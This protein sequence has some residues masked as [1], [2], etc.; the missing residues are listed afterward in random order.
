L[1]RWIDPDEADAK[2]NDKARFRSFLKNPS[3][4]F[5]EELG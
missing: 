1:I 2:A 3:A 5:I 4:D